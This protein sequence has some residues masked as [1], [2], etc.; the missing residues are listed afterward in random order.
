VAKGGYLASIT[1]AAEN[2]FVTNLISSDPRFWDVNSSGTFG[3]WVG[4]YQYDKLAEP[5]GHWAWTSGEAW[6]YTNWN[7]DAPE[8]NNAYNREDY[9][10][11]MRSNAGV[12]G[13]WKEVDP[14]LW[15][16]GRRVFVV[17]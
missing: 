4:G 14:V 9:L 5:A 10:Q 11:L 12:W 3:P 15:T 8:P 7:P 6:N 17:G 16:T 13:T 1:S 2:S